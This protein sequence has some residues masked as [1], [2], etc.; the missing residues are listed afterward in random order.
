MSFSDSV[1]R[2]IFD[3][4]KGRCEKCKKEIVFGNHEEGLRGAWD[5]HH[6]T[7]VKSGGK[8]ITSNG[9]ALCLACHKE[10]NTYGSH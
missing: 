6:K 7:S 1:R 3:N 9:K 8:D 10:T 2:E 5:A 4:A